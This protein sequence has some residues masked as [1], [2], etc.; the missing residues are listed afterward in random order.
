MKAWD[1]RHYSA[2]YLR[3]KI[4]GDKQ[5]IE[6]LLEIA[7]NR[8]LN[9][10]KKRPYISNSFRSDSYERVE[11]FVQEHPEYTQ[12]FMYLGLQNLAG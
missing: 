11:E 2:P 1:D 3:A 6:D 4:P 12:D 7:T 9:I 8:G 5:D 10:T